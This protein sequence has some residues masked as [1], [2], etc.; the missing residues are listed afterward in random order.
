MF[1]VRVSPFEPGEEAAMVAHTHTHTLRKGYTHSHL[2]TGS[3]PSQVT[4]KHL[5]C[6]FAHSCLCHMTLFFC[7]SLCLDEVMTS[8]FL[9]SITGR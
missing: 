1:S 5:T 3:F 2:H 4:R 6:H 9:S 7:A 8:D